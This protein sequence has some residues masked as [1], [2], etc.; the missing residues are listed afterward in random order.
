MFRH[1]RPRVTKHWRHG[2]LCSWARGANGRSNPDAVVVRMKLRQVSGMGAHAIRCGTDLASLTRARMS[3]ISFA[4][5]V[6]RR[7]A[8]SP[9]EAVALTL[10]VARILDDRRDRGEPAGIPPHDEILLSSSGEGSFS[11]V[12]VATRG[13]EGTQLARVLHRLLRLD[14]AASDRSHVPGGLLVAL[15]RTL[16]QIDLPPLTRDQFVRALRRFAAVDGIAL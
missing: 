3:H 2:W 10:A 5:L 4:D 1:W 16:R 8:V 15:S 11:C 9:A 7:A 14:E 12:E 13:D 6:D